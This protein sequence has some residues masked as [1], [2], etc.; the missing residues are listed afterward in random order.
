M[1]ETQTQTQTGYFWEA[2]FF[3]K[4]DGSVNRPI[5]SRKEFPTVREAV[6]ALLAAGGGAA[7][8]RLMGPCDGEIV[9][10]FRVL[11]EEKRKLAPGFYLNWSPL[12]Q[13][14]RP[15]R[16]IIP[17]PGHPEAIRKG[18]ACPVLDNSNGQ[19]WPFPGTEKWV[20]NF[21]CPIHKLEKLE[22][23]GEE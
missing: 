13:L 17:P 22:K 10:L 15:Y 6:K 3:D 16:L 5:H 1:L 20:V 7:A 2:L 8:Y 11:E 21:D 14:D 9:E 4:W 12:V 18:C 19:G 23:R